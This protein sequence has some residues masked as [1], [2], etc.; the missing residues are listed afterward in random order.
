MDLFISLAAPLKT[1]QSPTSPSDAQPR[2]VASL[3]AVN[4]SVA[5]SPSAADLTKLKIALRERSHQ[6]DD[7]EQSVAKRPKLVA[8]SRN[9]QEFHDSQ[10]DGAEVF[11]KDDVTVRFIF[12]G[13]GP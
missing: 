3:T 2:R 13:K 4:S 10:L 1:H 11:G 9:R 6:N 8:G 7:T 5:P 12:G